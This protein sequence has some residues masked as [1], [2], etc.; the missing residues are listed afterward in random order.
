T[1]RSNPSAL[2]TP[3]VSRGWR[4][5]LS[6]LTGSILAGGVALAASGCLQ[7]P[8]V[9]QEPVTSNVFVTQVPFSKIDAIDL[10]FVVDNSVSMADKQVL[11][12]EAVPQMVERLVTPDC[13]NAD[14][15]ERQGSARDG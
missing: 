8:V 10:L 3:R 6:L 5:R 14:T 7:R 4:Q 13:I 9:E 15:G 1:D 11:L 2:P 12:V